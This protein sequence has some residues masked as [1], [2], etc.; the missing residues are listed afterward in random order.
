MISV[1]QPNF[2]GQRSTTVQL[3]VAAVATEGQG[4]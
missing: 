4:T 2:E 3:T 1:P